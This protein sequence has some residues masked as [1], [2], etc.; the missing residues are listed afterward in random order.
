MCTWFL[1]CCVHTVTTAN[2]EMRFPVLKVHVLRPHKLWTILTG[3]SCRAYKTDSN[4]HVILITDT[5]I[6]RWKPLRVLF[7]TQNTMALKCSSIWNLAY[8]AKIQIFD[9]FPTQKYENVVSRYSRF[10]SL[11][12]FPVF[13][14]TLLSVGW[15]NGTR[16]V[17][18]WTKVVKIGKLT[19]YIRAFS[20]YTRKKEPILDQRWTTTVLVMTF[21]YTF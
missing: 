14:G 21:I 8:V 3:R 11:R 15:Y 18:S 7:T 1:N 10:P 6:K 4:P 20:I 13:A 9:H 5:S 19:L 17:T 12:Q 16:T 2:T